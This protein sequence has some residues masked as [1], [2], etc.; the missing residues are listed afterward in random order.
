MIG[1]EG[2]L[3]VITEITLKLHPIPAHSYAVKAC[4]PSVTEAATAASQV[5]SHIHIS[6]SSNIE[7][8]FSKVYIEDRIFIINLLTLYYTYIY[9]V[10]DKS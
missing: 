5:S 7:Q 1:S 8:A 10:Y 2:T 6:L 9:Y 4:F 3:A